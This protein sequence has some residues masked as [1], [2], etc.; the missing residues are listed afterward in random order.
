[1][2][3]SPQGTLPRPS[4]RR[5]LA[6]SFAALAFGLFSAMALFEYLA[7]D[8]ELDR[9]QRQEID[10]T[11]TVVLHLIDEMRTERDTNLL[12]H[13]L[14]D[15]RLGHRGVRIWLI[16]PAGDIV[17]GDSPIPASLRDSSERS[18]G[19]RQPRIHTV[20][21]T[22]GGV[23][24]GVV[25]TLRDSPNAQVARFVLTVGDDEHN[26]LR[27]SLAR[28]LVLGLVV[29][30]TLATILGVWL[31]RR[32]L[33]PLQAI[34]AQANALSA[35]AI[36]ARLPEE[37]VDAEI[38]DLVASFNRA[39][40]RME[41]ALRQQEAFSADVAHELNTP[42][43]TLIAGSEVALATGADVYQMREQ[44]A[45]NLDELHRLETIVADML[46]LA[47]VDQGEV[48][49]QFP[50]SSLAAIVQDV[51]EYHEAVLAEAGLQGRIVGDGV[52]EVDASL[53]KRAV[54]NLLSNATRFARAGTVV[55]V[56][57]GISKDI[58]RI[59][60]I[61]QGQTLPANQ[62]SR[63]FDRF[64]RAEPSR[65]GSHQH[66]GLGLAIVSAIARM[67]G[68]RPFAESSEGETAIGLTLSR[69]HLSRPSGGMQDG[70]AP[71][72]REAQAPRHSPCRGSIHRA[73]Q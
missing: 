21:R 26:R 67:H 12:R 55:R 52:A 5:R 44:L 11:A 64:Y 68:G 60:V 13:R 27:A 3:E 35:G 49:R 63:L 14:D 28:T 41:V 46:F 65:S 30:T 4:V 6:V 45:D 31:S 48:A 20:R 57:I 62:I 16:G 70:R 47:R 32:A 36:G 69:T 58:A 56:E 71:T 39:L 7:F 59:V 73:R 19:E 53:L 1:M 8:Q 23:D 40:A 24:L 72:R 18:G 29:G 37:G 51:V 2:S 17:Y 54:S 43:A 34:S 33:T 42:L 38:R 50:A 15:V 61:N 66:H 25:H 10:G 22:D 9:A